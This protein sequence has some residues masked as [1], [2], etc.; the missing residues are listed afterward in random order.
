MEA[1]KCLWKLF[2][3]SSRGFQENKNISLHNRHLHRATCILHWSPDNCWEL[4]RRMSTQGRSL[5]SSSRN[6]LDSGKKQSKKADFTEKNE[7]TNPDLDSALF[8]TRWEI[9]QFIFMLKPAKNLKRKKKKKPV[10]FKRPVACLVNTIVIHVENPVIELPT[11]SGATSCSFSFC[12]C[13]CYSCQAQ[14]VAFYSCF[15]IYL[16]SKSKEGKKFR[17][18][19][20]NL[21]SFAVKATFRF[22]TG[23]SVLKDS[24]SLG[25]VIHWTG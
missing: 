13:Y 23:S 3:W 19:T 15:Q 2:F 20:L 17:F 8:P 10:L 9:A 11:C 7:R 1:M 5:L 6:A 12:C 21:R 4:L 24:S 22:N 25:Q 14:E 18:V 16:M